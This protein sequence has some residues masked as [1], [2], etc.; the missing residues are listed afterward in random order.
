MNKVAKGFLIAIIV[1][2]LIILAPIVLIFTT[3]AGAT[4]YNKAKDYIAGKTYAKPVVNS[5]PKEFLTVEGHI[6]K[7]LSVKLIV[8]Y[9]TN[10]PKCDVTTNWLEGVSG[11]KGYDLVYQLTPNPQGQY[12]VQLPLDGLVSGECHWRSEA[13]YYHVFTSHAQLQSQDH[14]ALSIFRSGLHKSTLPFELTVKCKT[15]SFEKSLVFACDNFYGNQVNA[16]VFNKARN[17][18]INFTQTEL[19]K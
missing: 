3:V 10:N 8:N 19:N 14:Y 18:T 15:F 9:E 2:V 13:I 4:Y 6:K 7:G 16:I 5:H 12:E 11:A 1:I 17:I